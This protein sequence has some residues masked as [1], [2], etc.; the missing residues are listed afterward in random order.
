MSASAD[1]G[2]VV[3]TPGV[4][5]FGLAHVDRARLVACFP[6]LAPGTAECPGDC[7]RLDPTVCA[8]DDWVAT[9]VDAAAD[10]TLSD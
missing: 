5:S 10:A 6:D 4:R 3:D 8:L 7:D 2:W 9:T 1:G